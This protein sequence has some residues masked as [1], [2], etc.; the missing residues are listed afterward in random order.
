MAMATMDTITTDVDV[1]AVVANESIV[2]L[3]A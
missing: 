1:T 2:P 3:Y